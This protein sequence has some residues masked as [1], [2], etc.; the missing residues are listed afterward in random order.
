MGF[1]AEFVWGA[2]TSSYQVEG[3]AFEDGKGLS[4]WDTFCQNDKRIWRSQTGNVACDHYHRYKEDVALMKELGL[5]AY[6]LSI[7]WPRILPAGIGKVNTAG[8][9]FYS[10][11]IDELLDAG[12]DPWITLFHWEYPQELYYKGGWL[13][14]ESPEW[15]A[16]YA[17]VVVRHLSDRVTHWMTLNEPQCF[18]ELGHRKANHAPGIILDQRD[19]LLAGHHSLISHGKAVQAMRSAS[20]RNIKIG[21]APAAFPR[22]PGSTRKKDVDMAYDIT[23]SV[24][25]KDGWNISWWLDPVFLGHYPEDGLKLFEKDLP[26]ITPEDLKTICQP[27]DFFG[28][29]IYT[30]H[31][32][33]QGAD[34]NM[35]E[36]PDK[37]GCDITMLYWPVVPEVLYWAPKFLY[38]RYKL[39]IVITENGM[40]NTDWVFRDGKVHDPQRIDFMHRHLKEFARAGEDGAEIM[41]YFHWTFMDNF[42]W[43]RGYRERMGLVHIDFTTLKRTPKDSAYWYR[44]VIQSNGESLFSE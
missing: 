2:A 33:K 17:S 1:P 28:V 42:E 44:D 39:P 7:N 14:P 40:S 10:R 41:G 3:G 27:L 4:V 38:Q 26:R 43:A 20:A 30:G 22:L 31:Y 29:N 19:I 18:I 13:N 37:P 8:L 21:M 23:F 6:R 35:V 5:K 25:K 15:F 34:G 11:L 24:P 12:I 32:V 9:D 36:I 16:E